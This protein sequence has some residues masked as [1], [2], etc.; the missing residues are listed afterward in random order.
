MHQQSETAHEKSE[1]KET[2]HEKSETQKTGQ[3]QLGIQVHQ[4]L[5]ESNQKYVKQ[6]IYVINIC[7]ICNINRYASIPIPVTRVS[8]IFNMS[9]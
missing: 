4:K 1:I 3:K 8:I 2:A 5:D 9:G 7:H 6:C